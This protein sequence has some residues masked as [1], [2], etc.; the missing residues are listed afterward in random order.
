MPSK[1]FLKNAIVYSRISKMNNT[2][3]NPTLSL[4]SQENEI[5]NYLN[6]KNI[7]IFKS[8]KDIGS[9]YKQRRDDLISILKHCDNKLL[10]V[11]E[12]SRLSRNVK[13]FTEIHNI[14]KKHNHDIFIVNINKKFFI[15]DNKDSK[16]LFDLIK[17]AEKESRLIGER[18]SRT[19]KMKKEQQKQYYNSLGYYG[20]QDIIEKKICKLIHLLS[21]KGSYIAEIRDLVRDVTIN[22]ENFEPFQ[23]IEYDDDGNENYL[24]TTVLPYEM[25]NRNILHTL[26]AYKIKIRGE[27][28]KLS[29]ISLILSQD[30]NMDLDNDEYISEIENMQLDSTSTPT[31]T[32]NSETS[33]SQYKWMTFLYNPSIGLPPN[34]EI[35]EGVELPNTSMM[36]CI[37]YKEKPY[38][39]ETPKNQTSKPLSHY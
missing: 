2:L 15:H 5:T 26:N 22:Y 27:N 20:S 19:L 25:S 28:F 17:D 11:Y 3:N 29:D 34:I 13:Y 14:C 32:P 37:P 1:S 39:F 16:D 23:I 8:F 10:V 9:A 33:I 21:T 30:S 31:N 18:I 36:I 38:I 7:P 4:E 24:Q 12:A 6:S 35:P